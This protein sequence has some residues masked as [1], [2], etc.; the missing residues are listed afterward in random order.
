MASWVPWFT[1][2][3]QSWE[4]L[5]TATHN[6]TAAFVSPFLMIVVA[7]MIAGAGRLEWLYP[8]R[9]FAALSML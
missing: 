7:G 4:S 2:S 3:Q 8:L 9:F 6:P 1:T 5:D